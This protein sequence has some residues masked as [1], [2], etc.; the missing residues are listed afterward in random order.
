MT[1]RMMLGGGFCVVVVSFIVAAVYIHYALQIPDTCNSDMKLTFMS[2]GVCS[3]VQGILAICA[4]FAA[5]EMFAAMGH[6]ALVEKW[7]NDPERAAEA[8]EEQKEFET[9]VQRTS[10]ISSAVMCLSCPLAVCA[11]G[12]GI[13]GIVQAVK[14]D[15]EKC[16]GSITVYWVLFVI[17]ILTSICKSCGQAHQQQSFP[18]TT[19]SDSD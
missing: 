16:G 18:D 14:G 12:F 11:L 5:K 13:Y 8:Q 19:N 10:M 7:A 6:K 9:D 15:N 2:M 3:A 1:G 4:A 17:S